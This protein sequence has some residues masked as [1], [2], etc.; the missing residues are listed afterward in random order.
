[1]NE[2]RSL[3]PGSKSRTGY[4][5]RRLFCVNAEGSD[6]LQRTAGSAETQKFLS[7]TVVEV[8]VR[9]CNVFEFPWKLDVYNDRIQREKVKGT[10]LFAG[11]CLIV[12]LKIRVPQKK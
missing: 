4:D 1:M 6:V 8:K 7:V 9:F 11:K 12:K 5:K 10:N 2:P 3:S